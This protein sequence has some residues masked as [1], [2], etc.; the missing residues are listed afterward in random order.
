MHLR[1]LDL[2][3]KQKPS[4]GVLQRTFL[5]DGSYAAFIE[6]DIEVREALIELKASGFIEDFAY[7][8]NGQKPYFVVKYTS[9]LRLAYIPPKGQQ[10]KRRQK[11]D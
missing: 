5:K 1:L 4:S 11:L 8:V 9:R 7:I 2:L 6:D 3:Y 10:E